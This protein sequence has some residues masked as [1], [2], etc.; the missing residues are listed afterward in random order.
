[1]GAWLVLDHN[2]IDDRGVTSLADGL[3]DNN[4][5]KHVVL[6][7]NMI[8]MKAQNRWLMQF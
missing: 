8:Q 6:S 5:V 3:K 7:H 1:M 4:T 2:K